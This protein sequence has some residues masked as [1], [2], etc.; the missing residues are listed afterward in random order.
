MRTVT[1]AGEERTWSPEAREQAECIACYG[2]AFKRSKLRKL[3]YCSSCNEQYDFGKPFF[4]TITCSAHGEQVQYNAG[5]ETYWCSECEADDA[6]RTHE[7]APRATKPRRTTTSIKI[8]EDLWK[9]VKRHCHEHQLTIAAYLEG[10]V[11]QELDQ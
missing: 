10:L 1:I 7:Q 6:I 11:R 2:R 8:D 5:E 4:P 3:W 9:D